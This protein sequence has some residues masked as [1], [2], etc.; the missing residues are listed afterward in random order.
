MKFGKLLQRTVR[1][2]WQYIK[3]KDLKKLLKTVAASAASA[4]PSS[5][6]SSSSAPFSLASSSSSSASLSS[7]SGGGHNDA[8]AGAGPAAGDAHAAATEAFFEHLKKDIIS[9]SNCFLVMRDKLAA[10]LA[11]FSNSLRRNMQALL[12]QLTSKD[13]ATLVRTFEALQSDVE[14][15]RLYAVINY[16][17][18]EARGRIHARTHAHAHARA[19]ARTHA[20]T[21]AH[22]RSHAPFAVRTTTGG[23]CWC[24]CI[25]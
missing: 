3:Y 20:L 14:F 4:T 6:L 18:R 21:H 5:S 9:I 8:A 17:V 2:G 22:A 12:K 19:R 15:M 11:S 25:H 7:P 13:R 1:P 24:P 16:L 10:S 23:G